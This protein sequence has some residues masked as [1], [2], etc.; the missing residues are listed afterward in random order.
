[1]A[2]YIGTNGNDTLVG[3]DDV[4]DDFTGKLGDDVINGGGGYVIGGNVID[5]AHYDNAP[6]PQ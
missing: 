3:L 2:S 1:M 6:Q 4:S 5:W